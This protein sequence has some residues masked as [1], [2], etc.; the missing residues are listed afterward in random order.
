MNDL[1]PFFLFALSACEDAPQC[2]VQVVE[3]TVILKQDDLAIRK[4][5]EGG[6]GHGR[7][8]GFDEGFKQG[9]EVGYNSG[10]KDGSDRFEDDR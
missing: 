9:H 3:P 6:L 2:E 1:L 5:Y 4:A 7:I 8:L 10:Y